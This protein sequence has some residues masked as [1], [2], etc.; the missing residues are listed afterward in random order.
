[1]LLYRVSR[2]GF[3]LH[4]ISLNVHRLK[5][6]R[7]KI[8]KLGYEID[9]LSFRLSGSS[10]RRRD[11]YFR[12]IKQT[13]KIW[14]CKNTHEMGSSEC[15]REI[16]TFQNVFFFFFRIRFFVISRSITFFS[17][18]FKRTKR[19]KW[20]RSESLTVVCIASLSVGESIQKNRL[21]NANDG[22][23]ELCERHIRSKVTFLFTCASVITHVPA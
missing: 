3:L 12:V 5:N 13:S 6:V 18:F 11:V 14:K 15:F 4:K 7:N 20:F 19:Q 21:R 10:V 23:C 16:H 2:M 1:M 9:T 22:M 8:Q 17:T